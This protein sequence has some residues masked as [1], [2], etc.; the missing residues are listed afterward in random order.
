MTER[1]ETMPIDCAQAREDIDA[2]AIGAL[3][4]D[5]ARNLDAHVAGCGECAGL[6]EEARASGAMLGLAAPMVSASPLLKARIMASARV[7]DE[8]PRRAPMRWWPAAA[9]ALLVATLGLAGWSSYLQVQVRDLRGDNR[10]AST[11]M[12]QTSEQLA[13]VRAQLAAAT[14][15]QS[16]QDA[17][18]GIIAEPDMQWSELSGTRNA[19]TAT[20]RYWWSAREAMGALIATDMPPLPADQAYQL[21]FVYDTKWESAGTFQ[22]DSSGQGRLVV[23]RDENG[24]EDGAKLEGF[25]VTVEP[26]SGTE[27]RTGAMVLA[28]SLN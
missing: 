17:L 13:S 18:I 15:A 4:A 6:L 24:E 7:L 5:E 9:A 11:A 1:S 26:A 2:H 19:P 16:M 8:K 14:E 25:A 27:T 12:A 10:A 23:K 20:A 3:D 28:S 21:W 22:V